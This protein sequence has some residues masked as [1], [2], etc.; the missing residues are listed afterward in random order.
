HCL[1]A[2]TKLTRRQCRNGRGEWIFLDVLNESGF[3]VEDSSFDG[4]GADIDSD[5]LHGTD[6]FVG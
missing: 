3:E 4:R 5:A 1:L 6:P 2:S